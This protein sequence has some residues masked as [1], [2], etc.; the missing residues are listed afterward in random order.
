MWVWEALDLKLISSNHRAFKCIINLSEGVDYN[1]QNLFSQIVVFGKKQFRK[2]CPTT[3]EDS[4]TGLTLTSSSS[5]SQSP[6]LKEDLKEE[7]AACSPAEMHLLT[8]A[9]AQ[10]QDGRL[11]VILK[12]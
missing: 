6:V 4:R 11:K 12:L 3:K 7:V 9:T 1:F 5:V 2:W 10:H 8:L